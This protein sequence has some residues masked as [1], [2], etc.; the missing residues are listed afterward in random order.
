MLDGWAEFLLLMLPFQ[1]ERAAPGDTVRLMQGFCIVGHFVEHHAEERRVKRS[2]RKGK[3]L[4][5][6]NT[7]FTLRHMPLCCFYHLRIDIDPRD[8]DPC[9]VKGLRKQ[10]GP[11]P[12]I[13][14]GLDI[15]ALKAASDYFLYLK[16][17]SS[18]G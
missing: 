5:R 12:N 15:R 14:K 17:V 1:D 3:V 9:F 7:E 13:Q 8:Y 18:F 10:S 6:G 2:V 16:T 4:C 11:S